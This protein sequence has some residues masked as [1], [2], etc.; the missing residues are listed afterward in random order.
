MQGLK[1]PVKDIK[2]PALVEMLK[3]FFELRVTPSVDLNETRSNPC[4]ATVGTVNMVGTDGIIQTKCK[5][6][7]VTCATV[8]FDILKL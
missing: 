7:Q 6:L 3:W 4:F 8:P 1:L 2:T 5:L